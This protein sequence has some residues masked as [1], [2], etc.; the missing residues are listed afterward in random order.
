MNLMKNLT[1]DVDMSN[2]CIGIP[3]HE[4]TQGDDYSILHFHIQ[5]L[6]DKNK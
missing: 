1:D 4:I 3:T 5:G 6:M 2:V